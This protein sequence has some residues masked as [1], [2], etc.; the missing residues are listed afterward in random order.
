[1]CLCTKPAHFVLDSQYNIVQDHDQTR[2]GEIT[3]DRHISDDL[4]QNIYC[5]GLLVV[6]GTHVGLLYDDLARGLAFVASKRGREG[7][8]R[9]EACC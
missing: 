9:D 6:Y 4:Y 2:S 7:T 1:M 8:R 5:G 3:R